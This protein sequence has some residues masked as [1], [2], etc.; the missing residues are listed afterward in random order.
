MAVRLLCDGTI[1][2]AIV[3]SGLLGTQVCAW[4]FVAYFN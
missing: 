4:S 3:R 1:L 2:D